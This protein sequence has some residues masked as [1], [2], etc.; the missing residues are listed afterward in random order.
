MLSYQ[1]SQQSKTVEDHN[2]S[3]LCYGAR[4]LKPKLLIDL[5]P[6]LTHICGCHVNVNK[7]CRSRVSKLSH[8]SPMIS[9]KILFKP[10]RHCPKQCRRSL[11]GCARGRPLGSLQQLDN[12]S[13]LSLIRANC[14]L[15]YSPSGKNARYFCTR[16]HQQIPSIKVNRRPGVTRVWNGTNI[17]ANTFKKIRAKWEQVFLIIPLS[18]TFQTGLE[19]QSLV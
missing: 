16:A 8:F 12:P 15:S 11:E 6:L 3:H 4:L 9:H 5:K 19:L 14:I 13:P 17:E 1:I 7:A 2:C 18:K 10:N